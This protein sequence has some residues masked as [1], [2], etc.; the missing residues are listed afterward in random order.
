M[1]ALG[2]NLDGAIKPK[3]EWLKSVG[4]SDAARCVF[5]NPRLLGSS[6]TSLQEKH[7]FMVNTWGR[8]VSEIE[9]FPQVFTYSLD[10]LRKRH[11]YLQA[12]GRAEKGSLHRLLRTAD[13]LFATRHAGGAVEE[14]QAFE[15]SVEGE[16]TVSLTGLGLEVRGEEVTAGDKHLMRRLA[17]L[18]RDQER[19]EAVSQMREAIRGFLATDMDAAQPLT[20]PDAAQPEAAVVLEAVA[21]VKE[22]A[23]AEEAVDTE[24]APASTGVKL[25]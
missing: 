15:P 7:D 19:M 23:E 18:S 21:A 14:Y 3:V 17:E 4:V 6:L 16:D 8:P 13:Y 5:K 10:Y 1:G 2:V 9:R 11:G 12:Y 25:S 24:V 22:A 20:K